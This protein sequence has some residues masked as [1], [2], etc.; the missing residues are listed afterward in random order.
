MIDA[1]WT[2]IEEDIGFDPELYSIDK[3]FLSPFLTESLPNSPFRAFSVSYHEA[4]FDRMVCNHRAAGKH[5]LGYLHG[6]WLEER[7]EQLPVEWRKSTLVFPATVVKNARD[8]QGDGR[9]NHRY[10]PF[11]IFCREGVWCL[12]WRGVGC[13]R[14]WESDQLVLLAN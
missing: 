3:L 13:D 10:F 12:K 7:S 11:L 14:V 8:F 6:K 2:K 4:L 5:S 9:Y 1:D